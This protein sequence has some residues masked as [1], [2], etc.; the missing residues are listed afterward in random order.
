M[1][2][3]GHLFNIIIFVSF[4][5]SVFSVL[6]LLAKKM[7]HIAL[8]LWFC[9]CG[10]IFYLF[11]L[12]M[13]TLYIVPPEETSWVHG[14]QVACVIW[15]AGAALFS[16]YY[17]IKTKLACHALKK[18]CI[19]EEERINHIYAHC[20]A[21][22]QLP[23]TPGLYF[24]TLKEPACV[25]MTLRPAIILSEAIVKQLTEQELE[26][27]LCHELAHIKQ[28]HHVWQCVFHFAGILHWFNPFVWIA[29]NNFALQCEMDCDNKVLS[30][31]K[32]KVSG[33]IYAAAM[34]HLMELSS[35]Q[36]NHHGNSMEAL[37]FILAKQRIGF[38][39]NAPSKIRMAAGKVLLVLFI[40][41]T[42]LLSAYASRTHFYP[43]PANSR[44]IEYSAPVIEQ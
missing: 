2:V 3:L 11:P 10:I 41:L 26:I 33:S 22:L 44:S 39:L 29:K 34:L 18:Y 5:G 7:L 9:V 19:C 32:D 37:G 42:V 13:P 6:T 30:L 40:A 36:Y 35:T 23:K 27:V 14:Y 43:Y 38:I 17:V 1:T 4:V 20:I 15:I 21:A 28:L 12:I 25:I 8:P 24:G 16:A 31:L